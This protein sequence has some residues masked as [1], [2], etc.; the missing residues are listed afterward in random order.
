VIPTF[1]WSALEK[2]KIEYST[3]RIRWAQ[4]KKEVQILVPGLEFSDLHI[5]LD[6]WYHNLTDLRAAG[7]LWEKAVASSLAVKYKLLQIQEQTDFFSLASIISVSQKS[8]AFNVLSRHAVSFSDGL[9]FPDTEMTCENVEEDAVYINSNIQT[10]HH[11]IILSSKVAVS[12]KFS[13]LD[14]TGPT[15]ADQLE[16]CDTLLWFYPGCNEKDSQ[17]PK[18]YRTEIVTQALRDCRLA[19][20]SAGC[21]NSLTV[22]LV[23]YLKESLTTKKQTPKAVDSGKKSFE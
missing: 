13:I 22:E 15:I 11:D 19:F 20:V 21:V 7:D 1:L 2:E 5:T 14:P 9:K 18:E 12:C 23:R 3:E 4:V 8:Q 16:G 6:K 17:P 10:A